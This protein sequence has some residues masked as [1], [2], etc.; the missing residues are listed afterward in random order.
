M[1]TKIYILNDTVI[2]LS[3]LADGISG[4]YVNDATVSVTI[5][6]AAGSTVTGG[7]PTTLSYVTDSDGVYRGVVDKALAISERV[8]YF[9]E[10]T[11]ASSGRDGFWR[12]PLTAAY[13][14]Q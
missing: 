14:T 12:I 13:R 1:N 6:D 3:A 2:E 4:A 7:G 9:A 8:T 11:A 5:K 10:I